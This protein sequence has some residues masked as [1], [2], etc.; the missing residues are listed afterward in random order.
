MRVP[1]PAA[2]TTAQSG[3]VGRTL[4]AATAADR[5]RP[6]LTA[7]FALRTTAFAGLGDLAA[8]AGVFP[9]F[10]ALAG[11]AG[12]VGF[13]AFASRVDFVG[14]AG[15]VA[16]FLELAGDDGRRDFEADCAARFLGVERCAMAAKAN[17]S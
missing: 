7:G 1:L 15:F 3:P 11:L 8:L 9:G 6:S 12:L 5:A 14:F 16:G 13:V 10:V 17:T 4:A 2:S